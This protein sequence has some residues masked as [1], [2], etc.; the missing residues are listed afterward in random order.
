MKTKDWSKKFLAFVLGAG[1][2][3]LLS[4]ISTSN[5]QSPFVK[6]VMRF[7]EERV[8]EDGTRVGVSKGEGDLVVVTLSRPGGARS[9]GGSTQSTALNLGT[10]K[11]LATET[12]KADNLP[13]LQQSVT[14]RIKIDSIDQNGS[15]KAQVFRYGAKGLLK[16]TIDSDGRLQ[17]EGYIVA[18]TGEQKITLTAALEDKTLTKGKYLVVAFSGKTNGFFNLALLEDEN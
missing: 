14:I 4:F 15:V 6:L 11:A 10:Y 12:F 1:A 13:E 7:G 2:V 17:L 5:A 3:G 18:S 8:L 9:S 16:G